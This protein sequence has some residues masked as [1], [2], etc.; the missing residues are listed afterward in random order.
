[1]NE[2]LV[3]IYHHLPPGLRSAA[4]TLRGW[5]LRSWRYGPKTEALVAQALERE[6]WSQARW[7]AWREDRLARIL[8][9]AAT[10][11][12]Y[13]RQ[14]WSA[15]RRIGNRASYEQLENWPVL[16]KAELR[17]N[18]AAFVADDCDRRA[19][20]QEHTSGTTGSPLTLWW[21][22]DTVRAWYA[23]FEARWRRW[24]GVSRRDRWAICGGQLVTPVQQ[25]RPPYW[26]WNAALRQLYLSTYHLSDATLP[27]YLAALHRY[28]VRYIYGYS[29]ALHV[30]ARRAEHA[31]QLDLRVAITAAEPLLEHQRSAIAGAFR[32]PVRE[33]YGMSEIV[34]AAAECD[35]G[36]LHLWPEVGWIEILND[37]GELR[38]DGMGELV[39][40]GLFNPDM[41]LIRY[42]VG[43]RA[44]IPATSPPCSCGRTLPILRELEGRVDDVLYTRDGRIVGRL[45]PVFKAELGIREAQV[46]QES[47][48]VVRVRY[49]PAATFA[50]HDAQAIIR[51]L[52]ARLGSVTVTLEAVDSIA[53]DAR[54]KFHAVVSKVHRSPRLESRQ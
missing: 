49:V 48:D 22:R 23:L 14:Q 16:G 36:R 44:G 46:I 29:S 35:S 1:M 3:R 45:D 20:F 17:A 26:V 52:Q 11:V 9:R 32:C 5:Y 53:R 43:D 42:R 51:G 28:R 24:Y 4:A 8:H 13:Y 34:A 15:Q 19:L 7:Q 41:P 2:G 33:T 50:S 25:A 31:G 6:Q 40:T 10:Q 21:S 27:S 18:P 47:L 37:A 54:G 12:P 38:P 39:C 30:L